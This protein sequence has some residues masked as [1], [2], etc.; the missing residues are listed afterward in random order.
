MASSHRSVWTATRSIGVICPFSW[1]PSLS[2]IQVDKWPEWK[3]VHQGRRQARPEQRAGDLVLSP[4]QLF[5]SSITC[6]GREQKQL[7]PR[8]LLVAWRVLRRYTVRMFVIEGWRG[9]IFPIAERAN[10]E[11]L[12]ITR[13]HGSTGYSSR[14]A[15]RM[16]GSSCKNSCVGRKNV[17]PYYH[18]WG[19]G[20]KDTRAINLDHSR[21]DGWC[22]KK[23]GMLIY[24][25]S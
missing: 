19:N 6:A 11:S 20:N 23:R 12:L 22:G 13:I 1:G 7:W 3:L 24:P 9:H 8:L 4:A 5:P 17:Q 10:L 15:N 2:P 18:M 21:W 14:K 16:T 25:G